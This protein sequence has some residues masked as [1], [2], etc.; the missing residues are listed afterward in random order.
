MRKLSNL[1]NLIINIIITEKSLNLIKK[2]YY[3]FL[4][5][6]SFNKKEIKFF[7]KIFF[8][9]DIIKLNILKLPFKNNKKIYIKFKQKNNIIYKKILKNI[10]I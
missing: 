3:T 7:F 5:Y 8:N 10:N 6:K 1:L 9:L 2:N 4:I